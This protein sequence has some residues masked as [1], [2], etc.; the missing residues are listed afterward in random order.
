MSS[1]KQPSKAVE[2]LLETAEVSKPKSIRK[3]IAP[4]AQERTRSQVATENEKYG[5]PSTIRLYDTTWQ[6]IANAA[7]QHGVSKR[8]LHEFLL[9]AGLRLLDLKR[10]ELPVRQRDDERGVVVDLPNPPD[11]YLEPTDS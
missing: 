4:E 3:R 7:R 1:S 8:Q 10:I 11:T 9:L 5:R 6:A 2:E